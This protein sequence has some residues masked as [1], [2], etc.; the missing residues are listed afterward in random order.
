MIAGISRLGGVTGVNFF[1][2]H[3]GDPWIVFV[4]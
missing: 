3:I 1:S 4:A 2:S